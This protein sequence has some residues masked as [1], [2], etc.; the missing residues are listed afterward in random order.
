MIIGR[1]WFEDFQELSFLDDKIFHA[2]WL[3]EAYMQ[4][5][6]QFKSNGPPESDRS[7]KLPVRRHRSEARGRGLL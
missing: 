7:Q 5:V 3:S 6:E 4:S 2:F 1:I